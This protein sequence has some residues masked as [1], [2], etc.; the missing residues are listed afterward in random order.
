MLNSKETMIAN[1]LNNRGI[2][3]PSI[4]EAFA[5]I[6]KRDFVPAIYKRI[7]YMDM[8]IPMFYGVILRPYVIANIASSLLK[9]IAEKSVLVVGDVCGYTGTFFSKLARH[10]VIGSIQNEATER[11]RNKVNISVMNVYDI[12][13]KFDTIFF[14]SGFY[15]SETIAGICKQF[16]NKNGL[17]ISMISPLSDFR[18]SQFDFFDTVVNL[19]NGDTTLKLLEM[20]LFLPSDYIK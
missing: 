15:R 3:E 11:L 16:L 20:P 9:S 4:I 5:S 1:Q 17:A 18:N 14:D 8:E 10:V 19:H 7:A 2:C 6:D 12:K 13:T